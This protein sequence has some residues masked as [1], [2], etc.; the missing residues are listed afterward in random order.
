MIQFWHGFS[1]EK[2]MGNRENQNMKYNTSSLHTQTT[3]KHESMEWN[4]DCCNVSCF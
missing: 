1:R 2:D 3:E 4:M